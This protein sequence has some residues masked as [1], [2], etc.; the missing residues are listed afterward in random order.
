MKIGG[1]LRDFMYCLFS[2]NDLHNFF[3]F[4]STA[5]ETVFAILKE[6]EGNGKM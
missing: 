6:G 4:L 3:S 5:L 1:H 2:T